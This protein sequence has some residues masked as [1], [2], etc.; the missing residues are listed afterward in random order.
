[1]TRI[2]GSRK[3]QEYK[4]GARR[5]GCKVVSDYISFISYLG[6]PKV[7]NLS[8]PAG[9]TVDTRRAFPISATGRLSNGWW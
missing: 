9:R 1:L 7:I 5:K 3:G 4:T 6:N 2:Q 8:L